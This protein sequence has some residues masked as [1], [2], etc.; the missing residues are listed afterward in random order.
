M[1][2]STL[3]C[4]AALVVAA[5]SAPAMAAD[6]AATV[7]GNDAMQFNTKNLDIPKSCKKFD[8]TLKHTGK[9]AKTVMGHNFVVAQT[10]D[11][12]AVNT[13]GMAAGAAADYVKAGDT[14]VLAH[15]KVVGGGESTT[16]SIPVDKMKAGSAY[17]FFCTF[18][19]HA[20]LMKGTITIK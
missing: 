19:G 13:D 1:N 17:S 20:T 6:C 15:S 12:T 7:E 11:L 3:A 2:R 18:Q 14:R 10:S 8:V 9:L 4:A 5:F 16:V